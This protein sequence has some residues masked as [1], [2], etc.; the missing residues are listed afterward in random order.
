MAYFNDKFKKARLDQSPYL[1]HFINGYDKSPC[2]TLQKILEE[3]QLISKKDISVFH[4][5][6]T[7]YSKFF[8]VKA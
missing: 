7:S 2:E 4:I 8:E 3:K 1:F 6:F 5:T